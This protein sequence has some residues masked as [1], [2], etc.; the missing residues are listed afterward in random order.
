[1]LAGMVKKPQGKPV[2]ECKDM[3]AAWQ[4]RSRLGVRAR[5][6]ETIVTMQGA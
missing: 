4:G 1:M 2:I 5:S 6:V 3:Q